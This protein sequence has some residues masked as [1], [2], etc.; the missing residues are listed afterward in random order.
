MRE[1]EVVARREARK[2]NNGSRIVRT[3]VNPLS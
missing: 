3:L 2:R 1:E